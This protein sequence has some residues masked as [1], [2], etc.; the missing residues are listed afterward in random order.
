M[1][2][3]NAT[4]T[5]WMKSH[6]EQHSRIFKN[7]RIPS[8]LMVPAHVNNRMNSFTVKSDSYQPRLDFKRQDNRVSVDTISVAPLTSKDSTN[9]TQPPMIWFPGSSKCNS[10]EEDSSGNAQTLG[11]FL[12]CRKK[13]KHFTKYALT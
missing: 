4:P 11:F 1:S 5:S 2:L 8:R 3:I 10:Q 6:N 12:H 7:Q 13:F 9:T